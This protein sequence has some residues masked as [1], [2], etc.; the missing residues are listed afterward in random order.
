MIASKQAKDGDESVVPEI[1]GHQPDSVID[2]RAL[3]AALL[4]LDCFLLP[5]AT[6]IYFLNFL[7]R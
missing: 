4:K 1:T 5:V 2:K 7:D 6:L 3:R